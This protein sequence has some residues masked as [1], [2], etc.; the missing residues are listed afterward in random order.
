M[1]GPSRAELRTAIMKKTTRFKQY[2][3]DPEILLIPVCHD[4]LCARI[5][6][7]AGFKVVACGGYSNSAAILGVPD[8]ALLTLDTPGKSVKVYTDRGLKFGC[9]VCNDL[10]VVPLSGAATDPR[11][12]RTLTPRSTGRFL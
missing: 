10:W 11:L 7:R 2:L 8:V 5:A 4:P 1:T 6:Q 12:T 9:Q 3:A